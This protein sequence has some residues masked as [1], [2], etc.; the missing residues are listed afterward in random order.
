MQRQIER[1][2]SDTKLKVPGLPGKNVSLNRYR[3]ENHLPPS[4]AKAPGSKKSGPCHKSEIG[5]H[6]IKSKTL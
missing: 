6:Q 4:Q 5:K 2:S 1:F 3:P